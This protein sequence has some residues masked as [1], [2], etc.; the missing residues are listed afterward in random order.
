MKIIEGMKKIKDFQIKVDDLK[1]KI[2]IY[3]ADL[4]FETPMYGADQK[5]QVDK[6]LQSVGDILK[7]ILDLRIQIQTTNLATEVTIELNE[8]QVTKTIAEWIHRRRDLAKSEQDLWQKLTDRGLKEG[9]MKDSTNQDIEVKIRR[10]FDPEERD[11]KVE[12]YRTEPSKIDATLE[13]VNATT[14]LLTN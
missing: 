1:D 5:K 9:K 13:V 14:D 12:L 4:N 7:E 6:W 8:K 11:N 10:Y 3:C 2:K